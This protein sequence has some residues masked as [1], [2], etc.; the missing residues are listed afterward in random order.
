MAIN[1]DELVIDSI[2]LPLA[3]ILFTEAIHSSVLKFNSID[4]GVVIFERGYQDYYVSSSIGISNNS[5]VYDDLISFFKEISLTL[6]DNLADTSPMQLI[7]PAEL[8]LNKWLKANNY[9]RVRIFRIHDYLNSSGY[10]VLFSKNDA[11]ITLYGAPVIYIPTS[12]ENV[13][14]LQ[15]VIDLQS[16]VAD[17][18]D[19]I[20][21][22]VSILH[23]H[24]KE[25]KEHTHRVANLSVRFASNY[26]LAVEDIHAIWRGAMLH[27]IGKIVIPNSILKKP[28]ALNAEEWEIMR[29]HPTI[30]KEMLATFSIPQNVL[31]IPSYHH[32]SWDG[33]G[34]PLGLKG[35][36]IPLFARL[37]AIV[38]AWDALNSDRPYRLKWERKDI[39]EF[40]QSNAKIKFDPGLVDIFL[41]MVA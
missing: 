37:F 39:I 8:N 29:M 4:A 24:D 33:S 20:A 16:H 14:S 15:E 10:W 36:E 9:R 34:Y 25:T 31:D 12:T 21:G 6:N 3:G 18:D 26:N 38:D 17:I 5:L 30:A 2:P 41:N 28:A 19:I 32:E 1:F 13:N 35:T 7:P 22:W 40:L 23:L 27:D 11:P